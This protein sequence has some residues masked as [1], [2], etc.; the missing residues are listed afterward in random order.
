MDNFNSSEI[1]YKFKP[2]GKYYYETEI[3]P[4]V[5]CW[6]DELV[7]IFFI[8]FFKKVK[9]ADV[10]QAL[11]NLERGFYTSVFVY[12]DNSE[13]FALNIVNVRRKIKKEDQTHLLTIGLYADFKRAFHKIM[14][15]NS[16]G[17]YEIEE[18]M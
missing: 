18:M 8:Q 11:I 5:E 14:D 17:L 4:H 10:K 2:Y 9:D 13:H 1:K 16:G 6:T 7:H 3:F 12:L 15:A